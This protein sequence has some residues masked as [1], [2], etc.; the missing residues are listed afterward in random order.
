MKVKDDFL[1]HGYFWIQNGL[2]VRFWEDTWLGN[3]PLRDVYP[4]QYRIVRKKDDTEGKVLDATH[5]TLI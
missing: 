5:N 1:A 2:Q 4:S 3:K